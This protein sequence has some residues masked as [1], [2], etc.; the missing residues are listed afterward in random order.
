MSKS[1]LRRFG[2]L[3]RRWDEARCRSSPA[4]CPLAHPH[5]S[6]TVISAPHDLY[7]APYTLRVSLPDSRADLGPVLQTRLAHDVKIAVLARI[8]R[9]ID[10]GG[11]GVASAQRQLTLGL[12]KFDYMPIRPRLS[13]V[14]AEYISI[15][16]TSSI[17][18]LLLPR[19]SAALT[20]AL[21]RNPSGVAA[22]IIPSVGKLC[23]AGQACSTAVGGWISAPRLPGVASTPCRRVR[24]TRRATAFRRATP[25][26]RRTRHP[27]RTS[28]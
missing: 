17:K 8:P 28:C 20:S 14:L 12:R 15:C 19:H 18:R 22:W 6:G 21:D 27:R 11:V 23:S 1:R 16:H 7:W 24:Q 4:A 3:P 25:E 26:L 5:A 10:H 9:H 13:G 2:A